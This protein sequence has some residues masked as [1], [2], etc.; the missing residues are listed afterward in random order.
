MKRR[1]NQRLGHLVGI[2][3]SRFFRRM[4]AGSRAGGF[5]M[6][7]NDKDGQNSMKYQKSQPTKTMNQSHRSAAKT[8]DEAIFQRFVN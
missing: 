6:A 8:I 3:S 5:H 7:D 2:F 4:L 1:R